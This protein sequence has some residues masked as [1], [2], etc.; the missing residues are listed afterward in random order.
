VSCPEAPRGS[1]TNRTH[2]EP[3]DRCDSKGK[4]LSCM[5]P[6]ARDRTACNLCHKNKLVCRGGKKGVLG[7]R[8]EQASVSPV[9][10]RTRDRN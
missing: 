7:L 5:M 1:D 10:L 6:T 4:A 3:C 2:R 9:M 8:A